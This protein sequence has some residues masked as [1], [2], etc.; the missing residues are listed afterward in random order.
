MKKETKKY[1]IDAYMLS[2]TVNEY[3]RAVHLLPKILGISFNTFHNYR[4]ILINEERDIPHE[5]VVLMEQLFGYKTGELS[6][7]DIQ[8]KPLKTLLY[9]ENHH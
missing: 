9:P 5:K 7:R 3:K 2:L 1:K 4:K 8:T 6:N